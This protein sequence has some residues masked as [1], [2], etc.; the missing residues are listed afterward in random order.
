MVPIKNSEFCGRSR[1]LRVVVQS[2]NWRGQPLECAGGVQLGLGRNIAP[3]AANQERIFDMCLHARE[4]HSNIQGEV[5][6]VYVLEQ[7]ATDD[8]RFLK[9]AF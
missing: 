6:H 9:M 3:R 1:A 5:F 4:V 8:G 2:R 7:C